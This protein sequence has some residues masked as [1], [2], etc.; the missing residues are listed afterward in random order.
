M[1]SLGK[2]HKH[3]KEMKA[4]SGLEFPPVF[5]PSVGDFY[6]GM[7]VTIPIT[8][9]LLGN[10]ADASTMWQ[11]LSDNYRS[12][13]F[14]K[15]M[16][17][18]G[19]GLPEENELFSNTLADTNM[20]Q[21]FVYGNEDHALLVSRLDNLGKGASGAAVQCMNIMMGIDEGTGLE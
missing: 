14:V 7:T 9:R 16:P 19:E 6:N 3:I 13:H 1:Y 10:G 17:F 20:M 11:A 8:L 21:I 12:E 4:V 2:T 5:C 15:V 18:G